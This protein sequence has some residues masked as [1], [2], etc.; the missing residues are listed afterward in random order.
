[1]ILSAWVMVLNRWAITTR[2]AGAGGFEAYP[3]VQVA[4]APADVIALGLLPLFALAPFMG[5]RARLGVAH[6]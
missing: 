4:A 3:G 1:M 5:A 2:V 6:A